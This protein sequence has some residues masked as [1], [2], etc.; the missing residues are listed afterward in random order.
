MTHAFRQQLPALTGGFDQCIEFG[1]DSRTRHAFWL[2]RQ[3]QSRPWQNALSRRVTAW[4][5]QP[6]AG[7]QC[8]LEDADLQYSRLALPA[9]W[10]FEQYNSASGSF[11]S[12]E[13]EHCRGR[14]FTPAGNA[15]WR[16]RASSPVPAETLRWPSGGLRCQ[17]TQWL[18]DIQ[19][20]DQSLSGLFV[21]ARLQFWGRVAPIGMALLSAPS[22]GGDARVQLSAVG[23]FA[24]RA[25]ALS[26]RLNGAVGVLRVA[27]ETYH[28]DRWWPA[29][30]VSPSRLDAYRWMATLTNAR[31]RLELVADGGNPRITPWQGLVDGTPEGLRHLL[32][33]TTY[34][35]LHV[36]LFARGSQTPLHEWRSDSSL[37]MTVAGDS[38]ALGPG[39]AVR[40]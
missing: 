15:Q 32:R 24:G 22:L 31:Y 4:V 19:A 11:V 36:R 12:S 33:L 10:P 17:P 7:R 29:G 16:L 23:Q 2:R 39:P 3:V 28:F 5:S 26:E 37:L 27:D 21:G 30:T 6:D 40:A 35:A 13:D 18:G 38:P 1:I 14:L 25:G 9:Q 8:L 34:A 20:A